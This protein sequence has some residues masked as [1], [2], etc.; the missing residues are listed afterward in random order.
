VSVTFGLGGVPAEYCISKEWTQYA[1]WEV[2]DLK[3]LVDVPF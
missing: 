1:N 2:H 3:F